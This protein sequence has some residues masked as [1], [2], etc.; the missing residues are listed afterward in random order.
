MATW[1]YSFPSSKYPLNLDFNPGFGEL[2]DLSKATITSTSKTQIVLKLANGLQLKIIGTGFALNDTGATAGN[3]S[4]LQLLTDKGVVLQSVTGLTKSLID[5]E[6]AGIGY[7]GWD[8]Q[9]WLMSGNDKIVG[10]KG[11]DDLYGFAG[12]DTITGGDGD[13][14][15]EG[16]SGKD[17]YDGGNGWDVLSFSDSYFSRFADVRG[18][19]LDSTAGTVTDHFGNKETFKNFEDFRG[20]LFADVMNG[21]SRNE[22]FMGLGGKDK[23]DGKG[24]FDMVTYHRDERFGGGGVT[25]DLTKGTAIDGFGKTDTLLNIEGARGTNLADKLTGNS[26]HNY[27]RGGD[28]NDVIA[29]KGGNDDLEGGAGKDTFLFDVAPNSSSNHDTIFD[30]VVADDT[31]KLENSVFKALKT[32]GVLAAADFVKNTTGNAGDASDRII[33]ET[34]TGKIYY[35]ADGKGG[36]AAIH[37]ATVS[38]NLAMTAADFVIV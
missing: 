29:G 4:S 3:V 15:M 25:V 37:F 11:S 7:N 22:N 9:E 17:T 10:S 14:Y 28:G 16:G 19:V 27:F 32:T 36:T 18:I 23:I 33:Y 21:S 2:I 26:A 20:T 8:F 12:N 38:Q 35:D 24:G 5:V 31:I 34:D 1:T 13:D 6:D 30:F